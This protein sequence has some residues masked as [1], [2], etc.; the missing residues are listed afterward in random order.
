MI[1]YELIVD[2]D[3]LYYSLGLFQDAETA[4]SIATVRDGADGESVSEMGGDGEHLFVRRR[5]IGHFDPCGDVGVAVAEIIRE[6]TYQEST[7]LYPVWVSKIVR[8]SNDQDHRA[9]AQKESHE[10]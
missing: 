6:P 1:V 2:H 7:D 8:L 10:H 9:D 3:D 5:I 4:I